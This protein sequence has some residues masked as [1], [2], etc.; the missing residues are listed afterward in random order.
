MKIIVNGY[1][2]SVHIILYH[3]FPCHLF[4]CRKSD[5]THGGIRDFLSQQQHQEEPQDKIHTGPPQTVAQ[6]TGGPNQKTAFQE[7]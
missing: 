5:N 2:C 4:V 7:V 3:F 1:K 6:G